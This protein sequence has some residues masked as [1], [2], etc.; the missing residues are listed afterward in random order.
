VLAFK[1]C[2]LSLA[3]LVAIGYQLGEWK[4]SGVSWCSGYSPSVFRCLRSKPSVYVLPTRPA[5]QV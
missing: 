1:P 4:R 5:A 3:A 2:G